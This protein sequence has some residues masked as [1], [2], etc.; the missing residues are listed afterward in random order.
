M[1]SVKYIDRCDHGTD[2]I[3]H[4]FRRIQTGVIKGVKLRREDRLMHLAKQTLIE[5][6]FF[7]ALKNGV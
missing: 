1:T 7:L 6:C 5:Y 3:I 4:A 2:I